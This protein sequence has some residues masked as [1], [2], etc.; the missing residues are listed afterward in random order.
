MQVIKGE[1]ED[2]VTRR[3]GGFLVRGLR[4][5]ALY[6]VAAGGSEVVKPELGCEADHVLVRGARRPA[7]LA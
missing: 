3:D 2:H 4:T 6:G 1:T 7:A 5:A